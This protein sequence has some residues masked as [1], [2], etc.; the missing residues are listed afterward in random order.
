MIP[1]YET[2]NDATPA[3]TPL[4]PKQKW[5]FFLEETKDPFN[6]AAEALS[7]GLA[8]ADNQTSKYGEGG[9]AYAKPSDSARVPRVAYSLSRIAVARQVRPVGRT[10]R[11]ARVLQDPL[12]GVDC[13]A[14]SPAQATGL[15]HAARNYSIT[16]SKSLA[17]TWRPGCT[18]TCVTFPPT[19]A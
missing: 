19:G 1:N 11:S 12:A 9:A 13:G 16:S 5:L 10:S 18:S 7:A 8:Q 17:S 15:P 6:I 4:T 3:T 2:V 14:A